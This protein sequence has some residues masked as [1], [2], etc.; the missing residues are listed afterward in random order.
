MGRKRYIMKALAINSLVNM[1]NKMTAA[2][3]PMLRDVLH[4]ALIGIDEMND[5]L[6][7]YDAEK[8]EAL[9]V[10]NKKLARG[11]YNILPCWACDLLK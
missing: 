1:A 8:L 3:G 11:E 2:D 7:E 6:E 10:L 5:T 9:K 4:A